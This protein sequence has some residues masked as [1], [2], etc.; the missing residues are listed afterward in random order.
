MIIFFEG[1]KDV[2]NFASVREDLALQT[3]KG[4]KFLIR[5]RKRI[6]SMMKTFNP[7]MYEPE[8]D[9]STCSDHSDV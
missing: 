7:Y 5:I 4:E 9:V 3:Q 6:L 1:R 8:R 2:R